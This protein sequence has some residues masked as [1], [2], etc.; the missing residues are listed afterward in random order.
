MKKLKKDII[1]D[2][3]RS[4][5]SSLIIRFA[6]WF[7]SL[8][9]KGMLRIIRVV[10]GILKLIDKNHPSLPALLDVKAIIVNDPKGA[11][12]LR[13]IL[14]S[15]DSRHS[16]STLKGMIK[17]YARNREAPC[18]SLPDNILKKGKA[19]PAV[20]ALIGENH[21]SDWIR[22]AYE[23]REDCRLIVFDGKQDVDFPDLLEKVDGI[24]FASLNPDSEKWLW[25]ALA[26]RITVSVNIQCLSTPEKAD[27]ILSN[28]KNSN[29]LTRIFYP[30]FY[31]PPVNKIK[32]LIDF[33]EVGQITMIRV[34]A[35]IGGKGG[36]A[37]P[38]L[39]FKD[40]YLK[41]PAFNHLA[42]LTYFCGNID[43]VASFLNPMYK[44]KG[45]QGLVS[46][47]FEQPGVY[48]MLECSF[49]PRI[50]FRSDHYPYDLEIEISGTDGIGWMKRGMSQRTQ[51]PP[52]FIRSGQKAYTMGTETPIDFHW[53]SVYRNMA[54]QMV[55][56]A[57]GF[58]REKQNPEEILSAIK[59]R[60]QAHK[61]SKKKKVI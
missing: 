28:F 4:A 38:D 1:G 36:A 21:E 58:Q 13:N 39:N 5:A 54:A 42:L 48:G 12:A 45:G 6:L 51:E 60:D 47:K 19:K 55:G 49:A 29:S 41:H 22:E 40:D 34:R 32:N 23:D 20:I 24:E 27:R 15:L 37:P 35:I 30:Y 14:S 11:A 33:G 18:F 43:K 44:T 50:Y 25:K 53:N 17:H 9:D 31:Y 59:G 10:E 7:G 16:L 52:I 26:S 3:F 61:S 57:F 8:S 2:F 56:M 46:M